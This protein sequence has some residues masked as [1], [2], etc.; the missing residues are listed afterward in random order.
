MFNTFRAYLGLSPVVTASIGKLKCEL[1]SWQPTS[2]PNEMA[3]YE[4]K[5]SRYLALIFIH[6]FDIT[7]PS[8]EARDR[9]AWYADFHG[10]TIMAFDT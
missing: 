4:M 8:M 5:L 7:H 3:G 1:D 9:T 10:S 2:A 6:A